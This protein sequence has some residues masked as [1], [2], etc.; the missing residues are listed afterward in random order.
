MEHTW[1]RRTN[2]VGNIALFEHVNLL[3]PDLDLA[4]QFYVDALGLTRDPYV[5][6]RPNL[7]WINVGQ[8]QFHLPRGDAQRVR[9]LVEL[10]V[11]DSG[12]LARRLDDMS[13]QFANTAFDVEIGEGVV[14][15]RC[16]WGNHLR[17]H[18]ASPNARVQLGLRA[19]EFTVPSGVAEGIGRF[20]SEAMG[21]L[22]TV[23]DDVCTVDAGPHQALVFR[24]STEAIADYDGHHIAVYVSDFSNPHKWLD[25]HG[26][27]VADS[28]EH[29]YRFNWIVDP[30]S[31]ERLFEIEH[32]VRCLYNPL[33]NR[34]L[35]NRNPEQR[36]PT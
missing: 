15:I 35:A 7:V 23:M 18:E 11:P 24:G 20:Y 32:E 21:A 28:K 10:V 1:D 29:E 34:P 8:Q 36:Q 17:C 14:D 19:V 25:S 5:E 27:L 9:G 31:G 16:P 6:H 2:D 30:A 3:V 4:T 13:G 33:Y 26:L 22:V 12:R